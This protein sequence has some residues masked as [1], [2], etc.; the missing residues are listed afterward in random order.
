MDRP[1]CETCDYFDLY[2]TNGVCRRNPPQ[3][4]LTADSDSDVSMAWPVVDKDDWCGE[5]QLFHT[6]TGEARKG[7]PY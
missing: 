7:V 4:L 5:H 3:I 2:N 1:T 6:W